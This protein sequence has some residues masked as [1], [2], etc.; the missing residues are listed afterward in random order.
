MFAQIDRDFKKELYE[1]LEEGYADFAY[2]QIHVERF[3]E[4]LE[5]F[6]EYIQELDIGANY[7]FICIACVEGIYRG[8]DQADYPQVRRFFRILHT[9]LN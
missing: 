2:Q 9:I 8:I 4:Y 1:F 3:C 5:E 7:T 6:W